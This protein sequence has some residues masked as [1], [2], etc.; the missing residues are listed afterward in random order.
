[1]AY[2]EANEY[3]LHYTERFIGGKKKDSGGP[4][5]F[6]LSKNSQMK[7]EEDEIQMLTDEMSKK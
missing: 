5:L 7:E 1:V 2:G 6:G 4:K 3:T